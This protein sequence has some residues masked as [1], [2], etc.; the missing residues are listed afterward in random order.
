ML[1]LESIEKAR[2]ES[3]WPSPCRKWIPT[4]LIKPLIITFEHKF[5]LS[6]HLLSHDKE[7]HHIDSKKINKASKATIRALMIGIL[8]FI[9][10]EGRRCLFCSHWSRNEQPPWT[11]RS[12]VDGIQSVCTSRWIRDP[13][14]W[15][16]RSPVRHASENTRLRW[17]KTES[18]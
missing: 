14:M 17:P 13:S 6:H 7:S 16:K 1:S 12:D 11:G 3:Q 10:H 4:F 15:V 5:I 2:V 9:A 8:G 18:C